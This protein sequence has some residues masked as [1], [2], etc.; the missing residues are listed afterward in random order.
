MQFKKSTISENITR[1]VEGQS[2]ISTRQLV[3]SESER[4][5]LE[6]MLDENKPP[7][8]E[9][10]DV[11]QI[12]YLLKTP[13]RYPPLRY[14]SRFGSKDAMGIF[15]GSLD[16]ETALCEMAHIRFRFLADSDAKLRPSIIRHTSFV[17]SLETKNGLNLTS[18][19]WKK[20]RHEISNPESYDFAQKLGQ[21]ARDEQVDALLYYSART[22]E[23]AIN[24]A[25][26]SVE[27]FQQKRVKQM[28]HWDAYVD[29]KN[30][31]FTKD[32]SREEY[33]F[34]LVG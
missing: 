19:E 10:E 30:V 25:V 15:Y 27:V 29:Y 17:V 1:V 14:G 9:S 11:N 3:H 21:R 13:F 12:H 7:Y 2:Y 8:P 5:L 28:Q 32:G 4:E 23:S 18:G 6:I 22:K 16:I 26:F 31:T 33:V 24:A 20:H 34:E